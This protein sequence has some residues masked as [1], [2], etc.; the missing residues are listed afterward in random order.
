MHGPCWVRRPRVRQ[1]KRALAKE[2]KQSRSWGGDRAGVV[3]ARL[4]ARGT[5]LGPLWG[6]LPVLA[7]GGLGWVEGF[8]NG[9]GGGAYRGRRD[10]WPRQQR[11]DRRARGGPRGGRGV[12]ARS[13]GA[14]APRG[15]A[16]HRSR[17]AAAGGKRA[18][19]RRAPAARERR[20]GGRRA[21]PRAPAAGGAALGA[22]PA[23]LLL[24]WGIRGAGPQRAAPQSPK[25]AAPGPAR[26]WG[27]ARGAAAGAF[28]LVAFGAG[29]GCRAQARGKQH[30][31]WGQNKWCAGAD[32]TEGSAAAGAANL[33]RF[34]VPWAKGAG[35][36]T[37]TH[38]RARASGDGLPAAV[39]G[40]GCLRGGARHRS[41][42]WLWPR[43]RAPGV[44]ES[45]P[46]GTSF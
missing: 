9:A 2:G 15:R 28:G 26:P 46:L 36:H 35:A 45:M 13:A 20:C 11:H 10:T 25:F 17:G 3:C 12:Q 37:R 6:A 5:R 8:K 41:Q 42:A 24:N 38:R 22:G 43:R 19:Q 23:K 14:A 1:W 4:C 29:P 21:W 16:P 39:G 32:G 30:I 33:A 34:G 31:M 7:R 27:G 18:S 44:S 40:R